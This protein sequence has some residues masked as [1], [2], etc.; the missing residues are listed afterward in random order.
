MRDEIN[1]ANEGVVIP[2]QV[3]WLA[4]PLSDREQ[5]QRG[6]ISASSV[7]LVVKGNKVARKVVKEGIKP[8]G[9]W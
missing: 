3:R 8:V 6:D 5:R 4:N 9:V 2:V 7:V 1:A